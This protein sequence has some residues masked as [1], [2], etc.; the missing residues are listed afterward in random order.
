MICHP[1]FLDLGD[2]FQLGVQ[3]AP[4]LSDD[5]NVDAHVCVPHLQG[6]EECALNFPVFNGIEFHFG[7]SLSDS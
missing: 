7:M 4:L 5:A 1:G 3:I 2:K 6:T